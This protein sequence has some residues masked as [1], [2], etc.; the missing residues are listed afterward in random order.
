MD[1]C[2]ERAARGIRGERHFSALFDLF[3]LFAE[4]RAEANGERVDVRAFAG[5]RDLLDSL[6][7]GFAV[8]E[9]GMDPDGEIGL[10]WIRPDRTM[11]SLSVGPT[12][13]LSYAAR[14]R[15]GTAYGVIKLGDGFPVALT[16]LLRRLYYPM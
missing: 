10:D 12:G 14:L 1:A 8:P 6:P 16:E 3:D 15:D 5:A 7:H 2:V 11:V 9:I 13:D 4:A